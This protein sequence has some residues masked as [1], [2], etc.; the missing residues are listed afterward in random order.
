MSVSD[1][2]R[3]TSEDVRRAGLEPGDV[4]AWCVLVAGC[5]HL[6][7]NEMAARWAYAKMLDGEL[8]R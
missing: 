4:G 3:L 6:F 7:S 1:P 8:V 5:Y 2:F